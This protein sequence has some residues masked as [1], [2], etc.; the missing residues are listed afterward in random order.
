MAGS[1][2]PGDGNHA[3]SLVS[4][5]LPL[6]QLELGL[7][8]VPALLLGSVAVFPSEPCQEHDCL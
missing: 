8:L 4:V 5:I 2:G 3:E 7:F 1:G 6:K